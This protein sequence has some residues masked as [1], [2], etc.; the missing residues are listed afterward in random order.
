MLSVVGRTATGKSNCMFA[1]STAITSS[2]SRNFAAQFPFAIRQSNWSLPFI[3]AHR[4]AAA[5]AVIGIDKSYGPRCVVFGALG[6]KNDGCKLCK[7]FRVVWNGAQWMRGDVQYSKRDKNNSE[8]GAANVCKR[9]MW[10]MITAAAEMRTHLAPLGASTAQDEYVLKV[11]YSSHCTRKRIEASESQ[12]GRRLGWMCP[13]K[14][15]T[16]WLRSSFGR[17]VAGRTQNNI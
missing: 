5:A 10:V 16:V 1:R 4:A 14:R 2:Q 12:F 15:T 7:W 11:N 3:H 8:R 13:N 6:P 9:L 17:S